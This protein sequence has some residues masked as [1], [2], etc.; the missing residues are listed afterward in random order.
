MANGESN[1]DGTVPEA[2][3]RAAYRVDKAWQRNEGLDAIFFR[4]LALAW[5]CEE[6]GFTGVAAW[7]RA[8][9]VKEGTPVI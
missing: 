1:P 4:F 8:I 5:V 9:V 3:I 2:I 7:I 6:Y